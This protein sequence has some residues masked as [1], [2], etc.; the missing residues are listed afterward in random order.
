MKISI[1]KKYM[2]HTMILNGRGI[3]IVQDEGIDEILDNGS[4]LNIPD[5]RKSK[6]RR[7]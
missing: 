6:K 2:E 3:Y 1:F 4:N 7:K 5:L